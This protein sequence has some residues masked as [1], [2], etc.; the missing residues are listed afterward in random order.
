MARFFCLFVGVS[1]CLTGSL[2]SEVINQSVVNIF[3]RPEVDTEV[4]SQAIYGN[5]VIVVEENGQGW[6]KIRTPDG[7]VGWVQSTQITRNDSFEQ[8][9]LLRS[10]KNLF[11]HIYRV[12]DITLNPPLLTIPYGAKVKLIQATDN[13]ERWVPIELATGEKAW[14]QRGDV[15]FAPHFKSLEE[16]VEFSKKFIGL[17]YTWGG[18]SSYGFDCSGFVQMLLKEMGLLLPRNSRD[19]AASS[20]L[21][22]V[23]REEMQRGDLVFLGM[24]PE[25]RITHVSLY[26]G[27][28]EVIYSG[29]H[30]GSPSVMIDHLSTSRYVFKAARRIQP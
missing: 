1:I 14:I 17:P 7:V 11:A 20:L 28:D 24:S 4:D 3:V 5:S 13:G 6:S 18:V 25:G 22:P 2:C 30:G 15:D 29:V 19:Q 23:S 9:D 8:S 16:T 10:L 12:T 21:I 26:L 27:N